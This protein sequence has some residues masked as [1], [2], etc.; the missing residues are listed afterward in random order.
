[1]EQFLGYL[2]G[3]GQGGDMKMLIGFFV[4]LA[5]Y[6]LLFLWYRRQMLKRN[7]Q[8]ADEGHHVND[9]VKLR[10]TNAEEAAKGDA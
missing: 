9:S 8:Y 10:K 2:L 3:K 5:A 6:L 4:A 7:Q 1:M